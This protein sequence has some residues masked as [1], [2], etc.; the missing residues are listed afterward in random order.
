[1]LA[2]ALAHHKFALQLPKDWWQDETDGR[3]KATTLMSK[4]AHSQKY[5]T[6]RQ[7]FLE[8]EILEPKEARERGALMLFPISELNGQ[9]KFN[10]RAA[11]DMVYN[12]P[13]TLAD[14]GIN[15]IS[16]RVLTSKL[17][18]MWLDVGN[19]FKINLKEPKSNASHQKPNLESNIDEMFEAN[20]PG[21]IHC[22]K[23]T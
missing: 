3:Y 15:E 10:V 21:E 18:S 5:K 23:C 19:D 1:M 17:L 11:L 14:I 2:R 9:Y 12:E 7:H 13:K 8:M 22:K 4:V 6:G 20:E 16:Q